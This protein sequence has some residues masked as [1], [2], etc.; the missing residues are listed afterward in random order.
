MSRQAVGTYQGVA[1]VIPAMLADRT[2]ILQKEVFVV[3]RE[4]SM[5]CAEQAQQ[6]QD[7]SQHE[8]VIH[9]GICPPQS[10]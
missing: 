7:A 9:D 2:R 4:R 10:P 1:A 6:Q 3:V 8:P 5:L